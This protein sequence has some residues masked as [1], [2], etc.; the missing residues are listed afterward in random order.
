MR[1]ADGRNYVVEYGRLR[2]VI[3]PAGAGSGASHA[4]TIDLLNLMRNARGPDVTSLANFHASETHH[5]L[6]LL[7][8]L[9]ISMPD[10]KFDVVSKID[11]AG[12]F[13]AV[14]Q[15]A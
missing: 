2:R 15:A 14:Q 13:H 9:V 4:A 8:S 6:G 5:G 11:I 3:N 12:I 1:G 7:Q 10:N